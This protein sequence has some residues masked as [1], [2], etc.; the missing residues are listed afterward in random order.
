MSEPRLCTPRS[1]EVRP[2]ARMGAAG[3]VSEIT[4]MIYGEEAS[5]GPRV[6][7]PGAPSSERLLGGCFLPYPSGDWAMSLP[8][9]TPPPSCLPPWCAQA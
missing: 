9:G 8:R 4:N 5:G 1:T 7:V 6:G 2:A 3:S